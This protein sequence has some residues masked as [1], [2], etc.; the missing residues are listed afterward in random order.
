M[1]TAQGYV[2]S[3]GKRREKYRDSV[4]W[5]REI[6]NFVEE[7]LREL[8]KRKVVKEIDDLL[9]GLKETEARFHDELLGGG[10]RDSGH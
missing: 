1:Y 5:N 7:K 2:K 3:C 4:D 8:K 6:E 10:D 9:S